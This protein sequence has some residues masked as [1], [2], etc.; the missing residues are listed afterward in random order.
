MC[1]RRAPEKYIAGAAL[2][3][4]G[5]KRWE[6]EFVGSQGIKFNSMKLIYLNEGK[7]GKFVAVFN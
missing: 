4:A 2:D 7:I 5:V 3:R 6:V 1:L